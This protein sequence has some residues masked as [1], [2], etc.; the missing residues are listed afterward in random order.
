MKKITLILSAAAIVCTMGLTSC[1]KKAA[2]TTDTPGCM[3]KSAVNYNASATKDDGTCQLPQSD[4]KA[5][6]YDVTGLWCHV[7]GELGI[8]IFDQVNSDMKGT[9]VPFSVHSGDLFSCAAG[10]A[11]LA[12]FLN[13]TNVPSFGIGTGLI[14]CYTPKSSGV[15]EVKKKVNQIIGNDCIVGTSIAKSI[16]GNTLTVTTNSKF[17]SAQ[18]G[19][20]YYL[21]TYILENGLLADQ[22][23]DHG[24]IN[25]THNHVVR[26]CFTSSSCK[27]ELIASGNIDANKTVTKTYTKTIPATWKAANLVIATVIYYKDGT[28][29]TLKFQNA[30]ILE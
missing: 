20:D 19:V 11:L 13:T 23:T 7:C 3:D 6:I 16:S 24:T 21:A 4:V 17:L 5:P 22:I 12:D 9:V 27:G 30:N 10:D 25:M 8:P 14:P 2:T 26:H 15:T 28:G 1:K 18:S 29:P